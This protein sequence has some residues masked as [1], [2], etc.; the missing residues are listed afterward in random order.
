MSSMQRQCTSRPAPNTHWSA[1]WPRV[2]RM[3]DWRVV[4]AIPLGRQEWRWP[5]NPPGDKHGCFG[6]ATM[7]HVKGHMGRVMIRWIMLRQHGYVTG[8]TWKIN[9]HAHQESINQSINQM[10]Y[11]YTMCRAA[12]LV[13][14]CK[15][16]PSTTT[17]TPIGHDTSNFPHNHCFTIV[18][19]LF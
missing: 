9:A 15:N 14:S 19:S 18:G 4:K 2:E 1:V 3:N 16:Q 6:F 12:E 7:V 5:R 10:V 17:A 13:G 8:S 11:L